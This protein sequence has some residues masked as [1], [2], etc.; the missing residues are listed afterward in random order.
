MP[1]QIT[2]LPAHEGSTLARAL[3]IALSANLSPH[4]PSGGIH[5]RALHLMKLVQETLKTT[6]TDFTRIGL[7]VACAGTVP[8]RA[9]LW[10]WRRGPSV[11][12]DLPPS[13]FARVT[14]SDLQP[15]LDMVA[16]LSTHAALTAALKEAKAHCAEWQK[17]ERLI[18]DFIETSVGEWRSASRRVP[19]P[20]V[21]RLEQ[22]AAKMVSKMSRIEHQNHVQSELFARRCILLNKMLERRGMSEDER[23]QGRRLR[24]NF[25]RAMGPCT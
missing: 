13:F 24:E 7:T 2:P 19:L 25:S 17:R 18:H 11:P 15:L 8:E 5:V 12:T 4:T 14:A 9:F 3:G 22:E 16:D 21:A 10:H 1:I 20:E 6:E 23:G